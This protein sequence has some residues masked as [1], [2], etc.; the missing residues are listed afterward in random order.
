MMN[1]REKELLI[2]INNL[3]VLNSRTH[4][5]GKQ[6]VNIIPSNIMRKVL[7]IIDEIFDGESEKSEEIDRNDIEDFSD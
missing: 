3:L 5:K 4:R 7:D 2:D 1:E 6:Y